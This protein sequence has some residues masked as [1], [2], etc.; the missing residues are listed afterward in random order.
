MKTIPYSLKIAFIVLVALSS[1]SFFFTKPVITQ[2]LTYHQF[3]DDRS[4]FGIPNAMD[5]LSNFF[6]L[7]AGI[8][9][10]R[11]ILSQKSLL[12]RRSW[13]WF[14][15]S[16]ILVAPGSA[17]YHLAP[18]N[19][20]LVWDRLPMSMGFMALYTL[21]LSEHISLKFEKF[22]PLAVFTGFFSVLTWVVTTDLR[23][24]F[25]I[26]FSS[27][28]TIPI[29]L[30]LFPSR[31]TRKYFYLIALLIYGAAKWAEVK[32]S[33]IFYAT[34]EVMSGHTLKHILAAIGLT[35][36]WW[37]VRTREEESV[38]I[39]SRSVTDSSLEFQKTL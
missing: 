39:T 12:T 4:F 37:M 16:I 17:Y 14:F 31:F 28:V 22:L 6:F 3:I 5:V 13:F 29:I 27:F 23:F 1:F 38:A 18:D 35:F 21:L 32:D 8:L 33:E 2:D 30:L 20:T 25:W 9:G 24:Y 34:H 26:Q 15:L 11:E 36:L 19:S 7:I 10:V